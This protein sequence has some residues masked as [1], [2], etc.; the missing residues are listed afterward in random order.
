MVNKYLISARNARNEGNAEDAKKFYDMVRTEDPNNAEAKFFYLYYSVQDGKNIEIKTRF[1][2]LCNALESTL[3]L[4]AKSDVSEA[5]K[6]E[7]LNDIVNTFIPETWN[8]NRYMNHLTV[9]SGSNTSRVLPNDHIKTV[10]ITGMQHLYLLGDYILELFGVNDI[11]NNLAIRC[12]KEAIILNRKWYAWKIAQTPEDYAEKI[13]K[14]EPTY[15]MP[16]KAGCI[17]FADKR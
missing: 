8:L 12:W 9:G 11:T 7:T 15:E 3:K 10:S 6:M 2:N 13:K 5:E 14:V 17:S 1:V 16:K 4:I